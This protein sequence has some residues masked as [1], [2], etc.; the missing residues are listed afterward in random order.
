MHGSSRPT[1]RG[2]VVE[3]IRSIVTIIVLAV[4][5]LLLA[6]P[7]GLLLG[8]IAAGVF[9]LGRSFRAAQR[10]VRVKPDRDWIDHAFDRYADR[11]DKK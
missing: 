2:K 3:R 9:N 4:L 6:G 1:H 5:G 10:P 11:R 8:L 7:L